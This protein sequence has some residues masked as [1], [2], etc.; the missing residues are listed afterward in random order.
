MAKTL[1]AL[2]VFLSIAFPVVAAQTPSPT[3]KAPRPA[4]SELTP[5]QQ[6]VLAPLQTDWDSMDTTRRRKWVTIANRYP[7]MTPQA[8]KRL[9]KRMTDWAKLTPA[10]R[11]EARE[12]YLRI[13]KLPPK[14]RQE[15]KE[16]WQQYQESLAPAAEPQPESGAAPESPPAPDPE[17]PPESSPQPAA[18]PPTQ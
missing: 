2:I 11:Q 16:Q 4:W 5:A 10:Q 12:R 13:R 3:K 15:V 7:T 9:Q 18:Q 17:T 8:Q 6:K 1:A 14:K